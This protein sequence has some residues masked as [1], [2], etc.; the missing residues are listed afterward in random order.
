[1][2]PDFGVQH[3]G[4]IADLGPFDLEIVGHGARQYFTD[5]VG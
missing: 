5:F 3:F 2:F 4:D 1:M